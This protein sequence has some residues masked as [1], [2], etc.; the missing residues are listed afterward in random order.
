MIV[1]GYNIEGINHQ[2][3]LL[4]HFNNEYGFNLN[5]KE[6]SD[7]FKTNIKPKNVVNGKNKDLKK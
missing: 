3:K 7:I 5:F 1:K 6:K 4:N 2:E